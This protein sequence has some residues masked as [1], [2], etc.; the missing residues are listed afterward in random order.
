M[1]AHKFLPAKASTAMFGAATTTP[2]RPEPVARAAAPVMPTSS[3]FPPVPLS[4][5][6]R[7]S[8]LSSSATAA[9]AAG[10]SEAEESV[11]GHASSSPSPASPERRLWRKQSVTPLPSSGQ[12]GRRAASQSL[13]QQQQQ[14]Q[15]QGSAATTPPRMQL[16]HADIHRWQQETSHASAAQP[17][18][19]APGLSRP[20]LR[21]LPPKDASPTKSSL[22]SPLKPRTPG[23]VVDFTSSVLSPAE[24]ARA[25]HERRLSIASASSLASLARPRAA[26]APPPPA[27]GTED[28]EI[29]DVEDVPMSDAPPLGK[30]EE[31]E[32]EVEGDEEDT[33][34][35]PLSQTVWTRRH[36]L[37]LD[38]LLQ[39]RRRAP[40]PPASHNHRHQQQQQQQQQH[41]HAAADR[42]LG[43]TVKSQGEAMRLERWHLDVV[44]A[45]RAAVGGWDEGVLAKRLFALILGEERRRRAG[46]GRPSR[47]MFH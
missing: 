24:Q 37:L 33:P 18:P 19:P 26:F 9:A 10:T 5:R 35:P 41:H 16:S 21:P 12:S 3:M 39:L 1:L 36:W 6:R 11:G 29:G 38:E 30:Q 34:E 4:G 44:D 42:Y 47:I 20:L 22:R 31:N 28:E 45:F 15:Q 2:S 8:M 7:S 46:L 23:R 13:S 14:Q 27:V 32:Q 40:F 17:P 43:K 25:R